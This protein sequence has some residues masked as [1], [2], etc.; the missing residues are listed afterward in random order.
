[1]HV[2]GYIDEEPGRDAHHV[3]RRPRRGESG[4]GQRD[5]VVNRGVEA[6]SFSNKRALKCF[7]SL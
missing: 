3:A 5:E 2:S 6:P 1:M 7:K 4:L